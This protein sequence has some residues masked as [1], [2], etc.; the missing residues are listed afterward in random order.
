MDAGTNFHARVVGE[1]TPKDDELGARRGQVLSH[2]S[3][4][5]HSPKIGTVCR[6]GRPADKLAIEQNFMKTKTE[7]PVRQVRRRRRRDVAEERR[8]KFSHV[9]A[10]PHQSDETASGATG[11]RFAHERL[12]AEKVMAL[13]IDR[14]RQPKLSRRTEMIHQIGFEGVEFFLAHPQ[15][16]KLANLLFVMHPRTEKIADHRCDACFRMTSHLS[17]KPEFAQSEILTNAP[18]RP[19]QLMCLARVRAHKK[20]I[21]DLTGHSLARNDHVF[22]ENARAAPA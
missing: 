21:A 5:N 4:R 19:P 11:V 9:V 10:I 13:E 14:M 20:F 15:P 6:A 17:F 22:I 1:L 7:L 16:G 3:K 2:P 18:D 12:A 8:V